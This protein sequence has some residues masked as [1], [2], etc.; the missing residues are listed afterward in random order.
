M[1]SL[2]RAV[3]GS[4]RAQRT[5]LWVRRDD[6]SRQVRRLSTGSTSGG[7]ADWRRS[8]AYSSCRACPAVSAHAEIPAHAGM[9]VVTTLMEA[10]INARRTPHPCIAQDLDA[11]RDRDVGRDDKRHDVLAVSAGAGPVLCRTTNSTGNSTSAGRDMPPSWFRSAGLQ[12]G[13]NAISHSSSRSRRRK[14]P[15]KVW[16]CLSCASAEGNFG[17]G[18]IRK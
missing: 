3:P 18:C 5:R 8:A 12:S 17:G 10:L 16:S 6:A 7:G 1:S 11:R 4:R 9:T 13:V 15:S 2:S 14:S